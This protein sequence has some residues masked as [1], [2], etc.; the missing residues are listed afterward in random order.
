M[1]DPAWGSTITRLSSPIA[2]N[3]ASNAS[4]TSPNDPILLARTSAAAISETM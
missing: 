3:A 1:I 4:L 2:A